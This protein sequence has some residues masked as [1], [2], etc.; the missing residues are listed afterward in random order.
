M[1]VT[2]NRSVVARGCVYW[3]VG[4]GVEVTTEASQE[5]DLCVDEIALYLDCYLLP[6]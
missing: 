4:S 2:E 5:G 6:T 1:I 3:G